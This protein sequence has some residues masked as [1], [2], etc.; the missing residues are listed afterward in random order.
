MHYNDS[1][2]MEICLKNYLQ[3]FE[4]SSKGTNRSVKSNL[5]FNKL[6]DRTA[7]SSLKIQETKHVCGLIYKY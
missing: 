7:C 4:L 6:C 5:K 2:V 3:L 1:F